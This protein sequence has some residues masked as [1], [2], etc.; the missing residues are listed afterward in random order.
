M[1]AW[2]TGRS[3][4][5]FGLCPRPEVRA[6]RSADQL[7][8]G[9][10]RRAGLTFGV[11]LSNTLA[12]ANH[13]GV[14]PGDEMYMSGRAL[15]PITM[16]L[17]HKLMQEFERRSASLLLGRR[18]CA[19]RADHPGL[20]RAPSPPPPTCSSRA[21][22]RGWSSG[23]RTWRPRC[24]PGRRQPGRAGP[25]Q[26]GY[27]GGCRRRGARESTLQKELP[28]LRPA[29]GR[30]RAG[31]FDCII[32]PCVEQCAVHQD[33]PEYAWLIAQGEYD[34]ALEVI[35]RRNPLPG[36]TGYVCTHLCQ[37]RCTRYNYDQPVAIRAL[38]R[39]A[40]EQGTA[41]TGRLGHRRAGNLAAPIPW[42]RP[43]R[44]HRRERPRRAGSRL[45]SGSA[46]RAGD[47]L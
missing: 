21:A 39:F 45:L 16:N 12:M 20:R 22:T 18:R 29:Q 27:A 32:A 38:K 28:A 4:P 3:H 42:H 33:V 1:T 43:P 44:R 14:L 23:S 7:S 26:P 34:R 10:G 40:F 8:E 36:I 5:R 41:E 31:S 2:A 9:P 24:K 11:K 15:Y 6:G 13:K 35:L 25:R 19:E 30:I 17:F 47:Y 37:T 46:W